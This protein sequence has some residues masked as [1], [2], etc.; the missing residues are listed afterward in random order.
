MKNGDERCIAYR[1]ILDDTNTF[2]LPNTR[3]SNPEEFKVELGNQELKR[4]I[5]QGLL[6]LK[7][8]ARY[9]LESMSQRFVENEIL[10]FRPCFSDYT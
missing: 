8:I 5:V 2:Q 10:F 9:C 1:L 7:E 6:K 3:I 4:R